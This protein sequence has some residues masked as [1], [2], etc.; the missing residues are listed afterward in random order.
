M[1]RSVVHRRTGGLEIFHFVRLHILFVHRRTGGLEI[2]FFAIEYAMA[3]HRRTG[4][5]EK[6]KG[7]A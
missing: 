2:F 3:V 1:I 7:T 5:L 4:G 6:Y